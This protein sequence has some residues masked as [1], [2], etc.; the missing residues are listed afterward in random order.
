MESSSSANFISMS[1]SSSS[2]P[3]FS[4]PP[5]T[6]SQQYLD[7]PPPH[8]PTNYPPAPYGLNH[9]PHYPHNY[10]PFAAQPGYQQFGPT[11]SSYPG[12]P[13][14]GSV[15]QHQLGGF[16]SSMSG[17]PSSPIGLVAFFGDTG[18][19]SSSRGDESS[20]ASSISIPQPMYG[21]HFF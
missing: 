8:F 7:F 9:R 20:P 19:G 10:N 5:N 14:Q 16:G 12:I 15:G 3:D 13:Y 6:Y 17:D 11:S 18:G 21:G 2:S 1:N 4:G